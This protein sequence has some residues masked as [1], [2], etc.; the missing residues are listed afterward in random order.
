MRATLESR[1]PTAATEADRE[2]PSGRRARAQNLGREKSVVVAVD[3]LPLDAG[4]DA[5]SHEGAAAR[6]RG[7]Q[8]GHGPRI[9][10][11]TFGSGAVQATG[12]SV[13]TV[14]EARSALSSLAVDRVQGTALYDAVELA[15]QALA[16][17]T[18]GARVLVLLTDGD[19]VSS[20]ASLASAT[21]PRVRRR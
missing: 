18:T 1:T 20:E 10:V 9:A 15:A 21:P 11:V 8:G 7:R 19:D 12:F 5:R 17:D 16:A 13:S 4:R 3:L 6:V 2:R 14:L